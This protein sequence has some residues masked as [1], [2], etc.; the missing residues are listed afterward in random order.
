MEMCGLLNKKHQ[1]YYE[2]NKNY[3]QVSPLLNNARTLI[4]TIW[5][6]ATS[7]L[8]SIANQIEREPTTILVLSLA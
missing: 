1:R 2:N 8:N 5:E 6:S 4:D 3:M 7:P